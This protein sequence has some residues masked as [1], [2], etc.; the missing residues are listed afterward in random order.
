MGSINF[1]EVSYAEIVTFLK[2]AQSL[3][4]SI[5]AKELH[6]SQPAVSKRI[7]SFESKYGLILF[8]RTGKRLQLTPAGRV[9]Y[10]EI[11]SSQHHLQTAFLEAAAKQATPSRVLNL[12][13]DGMF[14]LPL[15]NEIVENFSD[16]HG[17]ARTG[18]KLSYWHKEDCSALFSGDA[19][20]MLCPDSF[21]KNILPHVNSLPIAAYQFYILVSKKHPLASKENVSISDL[22]G[23]PLTV[24]HSNED[25]PYLQTLRAMFMPYGFAPKID[26]VASMESLCF[27]IT[28]GEGVGIASPVFWK[29]L[30]ERNAKFFEE[31]IKAYPIDEY[32]PFS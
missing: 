5:A 15:L 8:I 31:S 28:A 30:N 9:F 1:D 12:Y 26:H 20:L 21:T 22:M 24:A 17:Y 7:A 16:S 3:N 14:D 4:M 25:S 2:V 27:E 11:I 6:V 19:D 23:V 13:Y 10:R 18:V 32:Y 29:R